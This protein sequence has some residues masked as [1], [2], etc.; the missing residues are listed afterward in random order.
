MNGYQ[1]A[2]L[3]LV[4]GGMGYELI[5]ELFSDLF[6]KKKANRAESKK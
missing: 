6:G 4:F 1:W 2:A 3:V 5:D